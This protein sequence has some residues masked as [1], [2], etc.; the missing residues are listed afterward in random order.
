M[1]DLNSLHDLA[2]T[3]RQFR[4]NLLQYRKQLIAQ[5]LRCSNEDKPI[6]GLASDRFRESHAVWDTASAGSYGGRLTSGKIGD[7]ARDMVD[8]CRKCGTVVCRVSDFVR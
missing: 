4:A 8:E 2:L 1:L 5:S 7:C 6:Q 3:C